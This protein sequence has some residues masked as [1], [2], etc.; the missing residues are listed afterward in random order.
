MAFSE[1]LKDFEEG[2]GLARQNGLEICCALVRK[3]LGLGFFV[4]TY[5]SVTFIT[6][7]PFN[8]YPFPY[9]TGH[10]PAHAAAEIATAGFLKTNGPRLQTGVAIILDSGKT[11][12][13]G[14]SEYGSLR[15]WLSRSY[16][17]LPAHSA[18]ALGD[19]R[20]FVE[21]LPA[22]MMFLTAHCGQVPG[23]TL[24]AT[25]AYKGKPGHVRYAVDRGVSAVP[26]SGLVDCQTNYLPIEVNGVGWKEIGCERELF[27]A[28]AKVEM[29]ANWGMKPGIRSSTAF[30]SLG[31]RM[32]ILP[33]FPQNVSSAATSNIS[34]RSPL[35]SE[36]ITSRLCSIMPAHRTRASAKSFSRTFRF[37]W[38]PRAPL[39][40]SPL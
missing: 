29:D 14:A 6:K 32:L 37:M 4:G 8:L 21:D 31:L 23:T 18:A 11:Q 24:E 7:F 33:G 40:R 28:F 3:K 15:E 12:S 35:Q 19:F 38:G 30:Q 17:I 34:C 26:K 5:S 36:A 22:D 13:N 39:T 9:P 27:L 10:L 20:Y 2:N 1:A 16:G 25:F